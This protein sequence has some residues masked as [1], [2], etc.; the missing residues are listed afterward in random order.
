MDTFAVISPGVCR[1]SYR[2]PRPGFSLLELLV[3]IF[4]I[5]ILV[6]LMMPAVQKIRESAARMTCR[7]NLKQLALALHNYH[8]CQESFPGCNGWARSLLPFLEQTSDMPGTITLALFT[9]PSSPRGH[10]PYAD[11]SKGRLFG[12]TCYLAIPGGRSIGDHARAD[13]ILIGGGRVR[14][15]DV[16]DG[17]SN[18]VMLGERPPAPDRSMGWWDYPFVNHSFLYTSNTWITF[19]FSSGRT[20]TPDAASCLRA[21]FYPGR[22]L[23][24]QGASNYCDTHH[25]WSGH[26]AGSNWAFGD[27]SVRFLPYTA[28]PLT[29]ALATRN[30]GEVVDLS[31]Y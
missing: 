1:P 6:G 27:G 10:E 12:T 13:G 28:S 8:D 25:F 20:Q 5:A 17:T 16:T 7:N 21:P 15:T 3:V 23:A 29:V 14:L 31:R 19:F 11:P 24:P 22:F 2:G 30:R 26:T 18:T 4:V 9:C